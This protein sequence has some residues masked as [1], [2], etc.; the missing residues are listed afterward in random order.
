MFKTRPEHSAVK[1]SSQSLSSTQFGLSDQKDRPGFEE[2]GAHQGRTGKLNLLLGPEIT[3]RRCGELRRNLPCTSETSCGAD[4]MFG[5]R[6]W[7]KGNLVE[8]GGD[9]ALTTSGKLLGFSILGP[10]A[11][12]FTWLCCQHITLQSSRLLKTHVR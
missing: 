5:L 7:E 10:S 11:T 3:G 8:T 1:L 2:Q 9:I 4:I 6:S 12:P